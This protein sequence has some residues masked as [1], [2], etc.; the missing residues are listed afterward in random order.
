M[1]DAIKNLGLASSFG[2]P[3]RDLERLINPAGALMMN[4]FLPLDRRTMPGLR[5]YSTSLPTGTTEGKV[6]LRHQRLGEWWLGR[7]GAPYPAD[8]E[9]AGSIPISWWPIYVEGQPAA[10]PR[11]VRLPPR[12]M[13]GRHRTAPVGIEEGETCW[14]DI[15][16]RWC[17]GRIEL[18]PDARLGGCGCAA[19]AMPPC[20]SCTSTMPEC[21]SCGWRMEE[22]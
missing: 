11:D 19:M 4:G 12:P 17:V 7:Y 21:P 10:W 16:G 14:R 3:P 20:G 8:H 22:N 6:W 15:G 9:H 18:I 1:T 2:I 5:E 13:P